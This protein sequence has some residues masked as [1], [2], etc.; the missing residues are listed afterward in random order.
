MKQKKYYV[1]EIDQNEFMSN[2]Y[3]KI[4][5]TLNYIEHFLISCSAVI[6]RISISA[7]ASLLGIPIRITSSA[8]ELKICA[9]ATGIKK[10]QSIIKKKKEKHDKIVFLAKFRL[11]S[12]ESLIF[13]AL[14]DSC[15]S[16]DEYISVSTVLKEY[17]DMKQEIKV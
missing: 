5:T 3:K 17:D 12:I 1:E 10:Y 11:K 4:C 9:I 14:I 8:I 13:K 2:K 6:G 15:I 16:H 7:F